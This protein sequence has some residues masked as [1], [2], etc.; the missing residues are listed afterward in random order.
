MVKLFNITF[1]TVVAKN[2]KKHKTKRSNLSLLKFQKNKSWN[3]YSW[4]EKLVDWFKENNF[5][6]KKFMESDNNQIYKDMT[7]CLKEK[8]S[9]K[10]DAKLSE[11]VI[12][13]IDGLKKMQN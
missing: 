10:L 3:E 12:S 2:S 11:N 5:D 13:I 1:D 4:N 9:D 7:N 6:G 8:G